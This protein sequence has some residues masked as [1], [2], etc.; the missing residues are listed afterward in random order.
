MTF[1]FPQTRYSTDPD[2]RVYDALVE[3][4]IDVICGQIDFPQFFHFA[5]NRVFREY[6]YCL[7]SLPDT[8]YLPV[9]IYCNDGIGAYFDE[10]YHNYM[11]SV[12]CY[13]V[14]SI[15]FRITGN[16]VYFVFVSLPKLYRI[17][18]MSSG[19]VPE[20][21]T[22]MPDMTFT[23]ACLLLCR[24]IALYRLEKRFHK[25]NNQGVSWDGSDKVEV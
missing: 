21:A 5:I 2:G 8:E 22:D 1:E 16:N 24:Q 3:Y 9:P 7:G 20:I 6:L 14:P 17:P 15:G 10:H 18:F 11:D 13:C 25:I 4:A 19:P 12:W 23:L